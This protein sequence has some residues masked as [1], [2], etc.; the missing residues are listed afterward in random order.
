VNFSINYRLSPTGCPPIDAA[1]IGSIIDAK[2]D[3]QAA[4]RFVRANA[5]AYGVDPSRISVGG[6]SA[7]AITAFNVA[8]GANDPGTSGTPGVSSTV[9]SAVG[10]SGASIT[11][12]PV[13]GDPPVLDFHGDADPIVS[14][15]LAVNMVTNATTAGCT[16][17]LTTFPGA[18]H[19]PY[20]QNRT[21]ILTQTTNFLYWT[22]DLVDAAQ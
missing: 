8:Y 22:M 15:Q 7:G 21:T 18:G 2:H 12:T 14:Y 3:A 13:A 4:V 1:C 19:V 10:L 20:V 17:Y 6:S 11:T 16:A 5:A 9:R